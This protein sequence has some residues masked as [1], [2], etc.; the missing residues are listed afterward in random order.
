MPAQPLSMEGELRYRHAEEFTLRRAFSGS[1]DS[2][3]VWLAWHGITKSDLTFDINAL[4]VDR[5]SAISSLDI[6][7]LD[8]MWEKVVH[9]DP[10]SRL[11]WILTAK[12]T[13]LKFDDLLLMIERGVDVDDYRKWYFS[14]ISPERIA[15]MVRDMDG[16]LIDSFLF[17]SRD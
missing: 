2:Y 11:V 5:D 1:D 8:E 4:G 14:G 12:I 7:E 17:G 6:D 16:D 3:I 13:H 10:V 9:P 15:V